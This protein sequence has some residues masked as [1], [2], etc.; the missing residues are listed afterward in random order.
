MGFLN[1]AGG[2]MLGIDPHEVRTHNVMDVIPD[3]L[4]DLARKEIMPTLKNG[5]SW[6]GNLQIPQSKNRQNLLM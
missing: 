4:M 3:S 1:Q 5:G 2:K 6:K